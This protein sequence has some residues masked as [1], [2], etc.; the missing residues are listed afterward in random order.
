VYASAAAGRGW[1]SASARHSA[2]DA[3]PG[4]TISQPSKN[5]VNSASLRAKNGPQ[6]PE[7]ISETS[8]GVRKSLVACDTTR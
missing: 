5:R 8:S 2:T 3:I 1:T 4:G 7:T 6:R